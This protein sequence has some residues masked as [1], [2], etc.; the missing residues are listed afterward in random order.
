M[1]FSRRLAAKSISQRIAS[2]V[3]RRGRTSIGTW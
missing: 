2:V 3:A 1:V